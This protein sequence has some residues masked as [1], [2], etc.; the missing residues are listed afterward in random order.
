VKIVYKSSVQQVITLAKH[1]RK[2]LKFILIASV[3]VFASCHYQHEEG[4]EQGSIEV[5]RSKRFILPSILI[6]YLVNLYTPRPTAA[7]V[8]P[9]TVEPRATLNTVEEAYQSLEKFCHSMVVVIKD[10]KNEEEKE[11]FQE[12][13]NKLC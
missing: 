13:I 1:K 5:H 7:R 9:T 10:T 3:I 11:H 12:L 8:E 6:H 4:S 2:M